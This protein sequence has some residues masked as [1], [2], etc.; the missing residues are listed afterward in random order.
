MSVRC[1]LL[2]TLAGT[3]MACAPLPLELADRN[4]GATDHV[5]EV[6][7]ISGG[8]GFPAERDLA[9]LLPLETEPYVRASTR[10]T[11]GDPLLSERWV[12]QVAS[13]FDGTFAEGAIGGESIYEDWRLVSAQVVA[14]APVARSL[15]RPSAGPWC[16]SCGS[17]SHPG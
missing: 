8:E 4:T 3:T 17:P 12:G 11:A 16:A 15:R 14:C 7:L 13:A 1:A 9:V 6:Q 5:G 10:T 2:T